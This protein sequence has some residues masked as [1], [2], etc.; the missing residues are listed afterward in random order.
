MPIQSTQLRSY[1]P[2]PTE[3]WRAVPAA[4]Y[5]WIDDEPLVPD[6]PT[7]ARIPEE[8]YG[9]DESKGI[10]SIALNERRSVLE[11]LRSIFLD[12][13]FERMRVRGRVVWHMNS[14]DDHPPI[15]RVGGISG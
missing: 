5:T 6:F 12:S 4:G 1:R 11:D 3:Q 9:D 13:Q 14:P 10:G 15:S 2:N 7:T 8:F